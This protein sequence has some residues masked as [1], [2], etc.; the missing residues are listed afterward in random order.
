MPLSIDYANNLI[1][2][3]NVLDELHSPFEEI[4]KGYLR[5]YEIAENIDEFFVMKVALENLDILYEAKKLS[6]KRKDVKKKLNKFLAQHPEM[7][8]SSA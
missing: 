4:E 3:S 5:A 7:K 1:E 2:Y 6:L 8:I